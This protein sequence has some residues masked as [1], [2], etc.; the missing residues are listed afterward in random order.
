MKLMSALNGF[1]QGFYTSFAP[2]VDF[3]QSVTAR[4]FYEAI[5][6]PAVQSEEFRKKLLAD[7]ETVLAEAGVV[8]PEG[9]I[10]HFVENTDDTVHIAIPPYIGG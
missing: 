3:D 4:S 8:L 1:L 7:P 10:V 6:L 5:I 9:V 2:P